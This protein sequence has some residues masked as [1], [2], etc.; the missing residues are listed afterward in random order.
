[1]G[2]KTDNKNATIT[3][4]EYL[5]RRPWIK[6]IITRIEMKRTMFAAGSGADST[7]IHS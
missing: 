4:D 3:K 5:S 2:K 1:M 7:D 6:P